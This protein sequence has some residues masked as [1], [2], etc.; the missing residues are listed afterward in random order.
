MFGRFLGEIDWDPCVSKSNRL[1]VDFFLD[2][3]I[4]LRCIL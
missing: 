3:F 1:R 2:F 4:E